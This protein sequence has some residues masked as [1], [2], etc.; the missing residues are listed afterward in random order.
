MSKD[1][2][3]DIVSEIDQ[4]ELVNALDQTRREIAARFDLKDSGSTVEMEEDKR[5][6]V[7]TTDEFRAKN[8]YDILEGKVTKRGLS[9]LILDVQEPE[10]ALGGKVRQ[11]IKLKRGLE[12]DVSKKIVAVVKETK[13]K[14]QA[15][16][17][18]EQVRVSGKNR[19]DLQEVIRH[20]REFG[21][22]QGLPL[23]F[24]NYR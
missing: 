1:S 21:E 8:I 14:V 12:T 17:Q 5:I 23:Q 16:I 11:T 13:L 7:T 9:P 19:D 15:S 18:G 2:S 24:N 4:Q 10:S 3:F 6:V 20:V 22:K